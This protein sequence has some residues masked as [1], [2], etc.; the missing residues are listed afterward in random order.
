MFR[1][2]QRVLV[3]A[4]LCAHQRARKCLGEEPIFE[5]QN[6]DVTRSHRAETSLFRSRDNAG[7]R[8]HQI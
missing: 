3:S 1:P 7:Q 4:N 2:G 8:L 6:G 5:N